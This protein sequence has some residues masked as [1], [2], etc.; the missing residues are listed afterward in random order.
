MCQDEIFRFSV[1]VSFSDLPLAISKAPFPI[2]PHLPIAFNATTA[3]RM[4]ITRIVP[5]I[6]RVT[7]TAVLIG[8]PS[9]GLEHCKTHDRKLRFGSLS[10]ISVSTNLV[11]V[12]LCVKDFLFLDYGLGTAFPWTNLDLPNLIRYQASWLSEQVSGDSLFLCLLQKFL[13][14]F[15]ILLDN[16]FVTLR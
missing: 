14:F 9:K 3:A 7:N 2:S 13:S 8:H 4:A 6:M 1:Y 10:R 16:R 12:C 11:S 15:L 5:Q